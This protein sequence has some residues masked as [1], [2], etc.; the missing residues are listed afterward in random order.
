MAD[1][2]HF[3]VIG[4]AVMGQNLA[5]NIARNGIGVAVYNRTVERTHEFVDAHGDE[6][7]I[8]GTD[9]IAEF[10][11]AVE[12]PRRILLMVKAGAGTDAVIDQLSGELDDGDILID[13]GNAHFADTRRR[14]AALTERGLRFIGT[15]ISGGE[16]G[17]LHGPSIMP[18][19]RAD[20]YEEVGPTLETIAAQ[21]DGTPC[22]TYLGPDGAGHYV[23]MVHNGIEYADMQLIAECYDL[24]HHGAGLSPD[25]LADAFTEWNSGDLES[26]L[27]EITADILRAT[28]QRTGRPMLDVILDEA[29]QK[30]TGRWTAQ[31]ALELGVPATTITEAVFARGVSAGKRA[32][33]RAAPLLSGPTPDGSV[34]GDGLVDDVRAALYAAKV[35]AYAQGFEQLSAAS[36][37]YG[38]D[39]DLGAIATIWRGGCIIRA[40][41]LDRIKQAY[42]AAPDLDNLLLAEYF[43]EGVADG[44]AAWRRVVT[45]AVDAG[46]AVPAL[47]SALSY[48]DGIRRERLPAN[49]IQAQRDYFG[50]HT[51]RRTDT[52][53]VFHTH[54]SGDGAEERQDD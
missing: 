14:E 6:G 20:A 42:D 3:G 28:D 31:L 17:A 10:L 37:E 47:A 33:T 46:I 52:D 24:L 43:R 30:G 35:V 25:E 32:R 16:E 7:P 39:L 19:G 26:F 18:G 27:I 48:Y 5:R 13:G 4:M 54:W 34:A 41:F 38:W 15:G 9:S 49:L 53:G 40:R 36:A 8:V 2:A 1:A 29:A 23:K 51:Y 45:R 22:C 21:V 12:R 11:D 44:Q 50:A